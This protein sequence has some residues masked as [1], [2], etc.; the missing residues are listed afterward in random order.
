MQHM[1]LHWA[2]RL[3]VPFA[4]VSGQVIH[5]LQILVELANSV[6]TVVNLIVSKQFNLF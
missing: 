6:K 4:M 1:Q 2:P 3:G 5:F